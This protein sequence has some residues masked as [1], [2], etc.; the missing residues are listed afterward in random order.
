[1]SKLA[2]R[3]AFK[4]GKSGNVKGRPKGSKSAS[5]VEWSKVRQLAMTDYVSAYQELRGAMQSG[6]GWAFNLYFKELVPKKVYTDTVLLEL[7]D[8]S[9]ECR[10]KAITQGLLAIDEIT[11]EEAMRELTVLSNTK[12]AENL[13]K[14]EYVHEPTDFVELGRQVKAGKEFIDYL[15]WKKNKGSADL[16][17]PI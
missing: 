3:S 1:M 8:N 14:T 16:D 13:N 15:Q 9:A 11:Y 17:N 6:E 12:I 4:K 7:Q 2:P 10:I 5:T